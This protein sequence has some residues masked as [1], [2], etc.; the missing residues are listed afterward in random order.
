MRKALSIALM[1]INRHNRRSGGA[2]GSTGGPAAGR[3]DHR[4]GEGQE[5]RA[6]SSDGHLELSSTFKEQE[7]GAGRRPAPG[8]VK[9]S[10]VQVVGPGDDFD[11]RDAGLGG[12]VALA[13]SLLVAAAFALRGAG[14]RR[15]TSAAASAGS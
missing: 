12:A 14:G 9:H 8:P 11:V 15:A 1:L 3:A 6:R 7:R 5:R 13:L 10:P 4:A 2:G